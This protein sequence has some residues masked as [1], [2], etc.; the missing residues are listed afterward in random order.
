MLRGQGWQPGPSSHQQLGGAGRAMGKK[1]LQGW[2][3]TSLGQ[4]LPSLLEEGCLPL[5]DIKQVQPSASAVPMDK[6]G[7]QGALTPG[8]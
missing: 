2:A 1:E 3:I 7:V 5:G 8:S 4:A 6:L